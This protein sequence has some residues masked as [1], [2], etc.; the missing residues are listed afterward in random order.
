MMRATIRIIGVAEGSIIATIMIAHIVRVIQKYDSVHDVT[1]C[2]GQASEYISR[3]IHHRYPQASTTT[4]PIPVSTMRRSRTL[5][6]APINAIHRG[7]ALLNFHLVGGFAAFRLV[8]IP[9]L[10]FKEDYCPVP[11]LLQLRA[12]QWTK[13]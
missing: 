11:R 1:A 7:D 12:G 8:S 13:T 2:M 9:S 5:R 6:V 3:A 4:A 10:L